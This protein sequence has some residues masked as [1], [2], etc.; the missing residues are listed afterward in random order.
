[1]TKKSKKKKAAATA[2]PEKVASIADEEDPHVVAALNQALTAIYRTC[3]GDTEASIRADMN[4]L[5]EKNCCCFTAIEA[6]AY[7][8][9]L[10]N[11]SIPGGHFVDAAIGAHKLLTQD[12]AYMSLQISQKQGSVSSAT[13]EKMCNTDSDKAHAAAKSG[14]FEKP[15]TAVGCVKLK[16]ESTKPAV[17]GRH[18]NV[19]T[20]DT[21]GG[22]LM[23]QARAKAMNELQQTFC[24]ESLCEQGR[25]LYELVLQDKTK[26]FYS[27]LKHREK[28]KQKKRVSQP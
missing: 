15:Q 24:Y 2:A 17:A 19:E 18:P 27:K 5:Q 8:G 11:T 28:W 23:Q 22:M 12:A 10:A 16:A 9:T 6:T 26:R 20:I 14:A 4:F 1:M 7:S 13:K 21:V 25:Q 3:S